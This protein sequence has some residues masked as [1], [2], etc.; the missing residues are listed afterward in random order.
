MVF[1][2]YDGNPCCYSDD[3]VQFIVTRV[4]HWVT[5]KMKR[6][7]TMKESTLVVI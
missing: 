7:G 5:Y 3:D 6:R 1:Y 4:K 2:D